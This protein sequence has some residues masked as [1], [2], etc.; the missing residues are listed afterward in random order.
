MGLRQR[1]AAIAAL[2][3]A[4]AAVLITAVLVGEEFP[5]SLAVIAL[6]VV[7]VGAGWY[8]LLHRGA[9]RALGA[10]V[11][12]AALAALTVILV[13]DGDRIPEAVIVVACVV[14]SIAAA[15]TAFR[16]RVPLAE[17]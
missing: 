16:V 4:P 7:A 15:R 10:A 3:L 5:R 12:L 9:A 14:A 1:I 17:A 2:V 6:A 11:A 8:G 13:F